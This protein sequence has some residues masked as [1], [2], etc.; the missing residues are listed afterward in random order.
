M[1]LDQFID[2][3]FL[4]LLNLFF[5]FFFLPFKNRFPSD[6]IC[7]AYKHR[8]VHSP[9]GVKGDFDQNVKYKFTEVHMSRRAKEL[10][11]C[12]KVKES[13][14]SDAGTERGPLTVELTTTQELTPSAGLYTGRERCW[15]AQHI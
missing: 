12:V 4:F 11:F 7:F 5:T 1:I 2:Y 3:D 13:L 8:E 15:A 6:P 9:E 10:A 14:Y